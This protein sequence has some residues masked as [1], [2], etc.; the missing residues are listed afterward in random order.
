MHHDRMSVEATEQPKSVQA[1][2]HVAVAVYA[3]EPAG[4]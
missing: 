2:G 4:T 1:F 3:S